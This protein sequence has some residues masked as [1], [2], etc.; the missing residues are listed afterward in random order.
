[1]A[2]K[3]G[4]LL[5]GWVLPHIYLVK[6]VT[7]SWNDFVCCFGEHQVAHLRASVDMIDWLKS[8]SVPESNTSVGGTSTSGKKTCLIW[9]P[10][11]GFD[12]SIMLTK[13]SLSLLWVQVPNHKFVIISSTCQLLS[14]KWP[15]KSANFL[16]MACMSMSNWIL[17]SQ[18][19]TQNHPISGP[20][21]DCW[22]I[23]GDRADSASMT[24]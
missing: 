2:C 5:H 4:N 18:I 22:S 14:I 12:R 9:I 17:N 16:F 21:T 11:N 15:F 10:C 20:S 1:M 8:M 3:G 13:F 24:S 23:P 6:R 7:M 19:P